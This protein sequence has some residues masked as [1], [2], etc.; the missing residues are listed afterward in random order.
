MDVR[1]PGINGLEATRLIRALPPPRCGVRVVAVTAQAFAQQIEICRQAGM[2]GHVPKPFKQTELL[3]ALE[4]MITEPGVMDLAALPRAGTEVDAVAG[5]PI[6]DRAAFDDIAESL[7]AADMAENLQILITR[8]QAL[9]RGLLMPG[10]L[11]QSS[12]LAQIA[13]KI[14]GGAGTFGFL[15]VAAAARCF[16][17]AADN[18]AA[19]TAA[20]GD[21]LA[22]AIEASIAVI[23]EEI[24]AI[25]AVQA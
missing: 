10:M 21:Q 19:E 1:M 5:V 13:H 17:L 25:A 7:S 12:E 16:E 11:S 4:T 2:D 24:H 8:C 15:H 6:L 14:A 22:A 3:A 9:L 18:S 23:R 20:L